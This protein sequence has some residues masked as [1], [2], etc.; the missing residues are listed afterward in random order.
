MNFFLG[1]FEFG[2]VN[3]NIFYGVIWEIF[4]YLGIEKKVKDIVDNGYFK[5]VFVLFKIN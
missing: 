2:V 3:F 4:N 1:I 5:V